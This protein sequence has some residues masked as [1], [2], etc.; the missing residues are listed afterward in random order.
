MKDNNTDNSH[1]T[2]LKATSVFGIMQFAK[3]II[4]II[5]NKFVAVFLGPI[6]IGTVGLMY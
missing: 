6:G 1:L 4:S 2:I 5:G 3:M